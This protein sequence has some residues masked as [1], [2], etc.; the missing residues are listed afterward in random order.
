MFTLDKKMR[1]AS[2]SAFSLFT[3]VATLAAGRE[4]APVDIQSIALRLDVAVSSVASGGLWQYNGSYGIYRLVV[5]SGGVEHVVDRIY[6]QW[7][8]FDEV[9]RTQVVLE[10]VAVPSLDNSL[11]LVRSLELVEPGSNRAVFKLTRAARDPAPA[12]HVYLELGLPGQFKL[13]SSPAA[14]KSP[15]P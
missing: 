10:S 3:G 12:E 4:V 1:V 7:L 2:A 11:S 13:I 14:M 15:S 6:A 5:L 8:R 9:S